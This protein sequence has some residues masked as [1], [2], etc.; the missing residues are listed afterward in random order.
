MSDSQA[1]YE[2]R[3]A[4]RR[5]IGCA[6]WTIPKEAVAAFPEAGSHLERY[7]AVFPAV[8]INSSFYRPHRPQTYARWAASVPPDF[9]FSVKLPRAI[10]HDARL[11]DPDEALDRFLLEAGELGAKLGCILVQLPPSAA[12]ESDVVR[13]FLP[14]LRAR[15]PCMLAL[16]GRHRTWFGEAATD[17][18][19]EHGVT[20]VFADPAAGQAGPHVPTTAASYLRLHGSPQIYYSRYPSDFLDDVAGRLA[21]AVDA[22]ADAW[23]IFDNTAAGAAVPNALEVLHGAGVAA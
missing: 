16:E 5:L 6:G 4:A 10:T 9:R 23:C 2:P 3:T 7:A 18:L 12:F 19:R 8:E 17:L 21:R 13:D 11:R 1:G 22:G 14:R 20:R 15:F